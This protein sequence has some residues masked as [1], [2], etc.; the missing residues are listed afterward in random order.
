MH[1]SARFANTWK[2]SPALCY[3]EGWL[4]ESFTDY[5]L[6]VIYNSEFY[7]LLY[8][9][10]KVHNSSHK[11]AWNIWVLGPEPMMF[12]ICGKMESLSMTWSSMDL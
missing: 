11:M 6:A 3:W 4:S 8:S 1:K 12:T 9:A 10:K 2:S 5:S 7:A